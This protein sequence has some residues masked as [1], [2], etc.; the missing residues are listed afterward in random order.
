MTADGVLVSCFQSRFYFYKRQFCVQFCIKSHHK[1]TYMQLYSVLHT[2]SLVCKLSYLTVC[3]NSWAQKCSSVPHWGIST[4]RW[5]L[6]IR[7]RRRKDW[8]T[9]H[10]EK[11]TGSAGGLI[12]ARDSGELYERII[13]QRAIRKFNIV[14]KLNEHFLVPGLYIVTF[15]LEHILPLKFQLFWL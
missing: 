13:L 3:S 5:F 14:A 9:M 7:W 4:R 15:L 11:S 6:N 1:I 10:K 8:R 12:W 2:V